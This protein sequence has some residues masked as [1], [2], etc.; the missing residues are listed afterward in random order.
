MLINIFCCFVLVIIV[1]L[2]QQ[3]LEWKS[4]SSTN[5]YLKMRRLDAI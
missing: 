1:L 2:P 5:K 4:W 3:F